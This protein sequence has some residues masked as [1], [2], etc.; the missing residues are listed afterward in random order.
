M[1]EKIHFS[2]NETEIVD[3]LRDCEWHCVYNEVHQK[4]DRARLTA[5]NRK[6]AP[7]GWQVI[8]EPCTLHNH[9]SRIVMRRLVKIAPKLPQDAISVSKQIQASIEWF[10]R[11]P[12]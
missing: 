6:I 2:P 10:N 3:I 9:D 4:D 8:S 7:R 5:I 11:L 12:A 1:K